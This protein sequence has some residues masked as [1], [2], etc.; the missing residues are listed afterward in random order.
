MKRKFEH[1]APAD[2]ELTTGPKYWRSLGE[3]A[4]TPGFRAQLER[5][6]PEGASELDGVDRRH[7]MKIMAASFALGGVGLAGCRRPEKFIL[8][9]GKSVEGVIPGLPSYYAT[10]MPLR[11]SAIPLL[12]ETHQGRPTKLEGNPS[13]KLHDGSASL[14][15][16]ASILDLYDPDRAKAHTR[17]GAVLSNEQV[18]AF[19]GTVAQKYAAT[20]GAGLAFLAE[21]S[22]SPTRARLVRELRA[23]LPR[24]LWAEYEPI[25]DEPP[26]S[27]A[28][29]A[30][31]VAVRPLYHFAK[32]RRILSLDADFL[33]G[34]SGNLYH[35]RGFSQGR[36]VTKPSDPMNRLYVA[37]SGLSLTGTMADHRLR[38]PTHH[39]LALAARVVAAAYPQAEA[40]LA[41]YYQGLKVDAKWVEACVA[42][43]LAHRGAALVVAGSHLPPEVHA[44][45]HGLNTLLEATGQTVTYVPA[46]STAGRSTLAGLANAIRG[47]SVKTL[48]ILGGN[49]AYNAPAD[50][51][52]AALQKS[53]E[54]VIR[55]G[56]YADETSAV[57]PATTTH[58]AAAH[59]LESWGDARA[60]D[61][62]I[63]PVQPM[64]LPLFGG[65][66]EIEVLARLAGQTP[67]DPYALVSA[68]ITGLAGAGANT[69]KTMARFLHDGLLEGS[70]Y[71]PVAVRFDQAGVERLFS[72]PA[73]LPAFS[74]SNLEVRFVAD[75]KVDDG[76]FANNGWLQ[77]CPDPIT[78][79]AWDNAILV[80]PKLGK[81]LGIEPKGSLL[82]VARKETAEFTIG[83]ENAHVFELAIGGRRIRG[84]VHIQPGLA[85][86]TVVVALGYGRTNS[87]R[88]GTGAGCNAY[89][90]R[91]ST[92]LHAAAGG[93][94]TST[95]ER[96]LLANTQEHWSM[97][98][99]DII[100]EANY[101][102][103][104]SYQ[105][106]PGYVKTIGMESHS[107]SILGEYGEKMSPQERATQIP[108]GN[109]L[110]QTPTFDGHH[111]WGMS[112][113]LN[114]CIGCNAC[115]VA[116]QAENN[117][118]IVGKQQVLRGREMHW[119]RIDRYYSSGTIDAEAFGG[120]GNQE[121]PEE[122]Q[123]SLQPM[124]CVHCELAPCETVCP[125]NATVHDSEGINT[126]AYNRCIGT[127]YCA[128]N[129]P[130]KVRR[131]NFFDW[132]QRSLDSLY[133]GP[134]SAY[135]MPELLQMAK[136]PE[137][138][139]RM[140]GVMEKCTY[141][142]QRIQNAKIQ[143]KVKMAQAGRPGDVMVPDRAFQVACEQTCPVDAIVFGNL[144]EANSA[145]NQAKAREQDYAVLG[146]L[147][148]R[149]RTTYSG[150]LRNPNPKMP[151][152]QPLPFS[153]VE[154]ARKNEP[155][156]HGSGHD[157]HGSHGHDKK[158]EKKAPSHGSRS[159]APTTGGLS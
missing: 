60:I 119:I 76:R 150:K 56:Y 92:S 2:S 138:T 29:A 90:L 68:T 66:T 103:T 23:K 79:I 46:E 99:R 44:L 28:Q 87:G 63:V 158:A 61:G 43:L 111:Q 1:P 137:V 89:P 113:D 110:Y 130:Y 32:A 19:L 33:Q 30:F 115:V 20:Q 143:H 132:N 139:V 101:E 96:A 38:V 42:D 39:M 114:T 112:I 84:P 109:S 81:E 18:G 50:L 48:V 6:F 142:V 144:L 83:K 78:R 54:E 156:A 159:S 127:R 148:V 123:I 4:G 108:R 131:F 136:N 13:F 121:I 11:R 82:Q 98:G 107:P 55:L 27:A 62:T 24:S 58:L 105:E 126:M 129:C 85:N 14:L 49:P 91:T 154:Y 36:K 10:A 100:R 75:H 77:E 117:I 128:N 16:Q 104:S 5:E 7:F 86:Y 53:V 31:G 22:S 152:Y 133:L 134:V 70:A 9:Y 65:L 146:Y 124:T 8:P 17:A 51:D 25:V 155:A 69:E 64:I 140:R 40:S 141:C 57:N 145:V 118:P 71:R 3:L 73:P 12:A 135:G 45:V 106:N 34:E 35:A 74:A 72:T 26:V 122:P 59:Y 94:L 37:E 80:S 88:V 116:C 102:G 153:R 41:P 151:D 21:E 52:W 125:V 93:K 15:A 157:D 47:G 97:E 149:P 67:V 147:N 120:A 95:G